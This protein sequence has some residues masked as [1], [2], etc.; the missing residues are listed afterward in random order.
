MRVLS[1]D[2]GTK[3]LAYCDVTVTDSFSVNSWAVLNCVPVELNV[4]E[5]A[6][7]DLVPYFVSMVQENLCLWNSEVYDYILIENQPMGGRGSARNLKTKVLSHILQGLLM[8]YTK[9][10][11][12][13]V[14]PGLKLKDM[15]KLE[16]KSSYRENKMYAIKKTMELLES[17]ECLSKDALKII[18]KK[19]TK[20]DDLADAFLQGYYFATL[21]SNGSM[22]IKVVIMSCVKTDVETKKPKR[23]KKIDKSEKL[24]QVT[25][26]EPVEPVETKVEPVESNNS[27]IE[28]K[29]EF[30]KVHLDVKLDDVQKVA[31]KKRVRSN[32]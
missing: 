2:V 28:H 24:E 15:P 7:G 26:V 32:K 12:Q 6:L 18:A 22:E 30:S 31:G 3:N 25:K 27:Q 10:A 17:D 8:P 21:V 11:I 20:K 9:N 29:V 1:F 14:H 16:G 23:S 4:N 5:T 19:K 13:F